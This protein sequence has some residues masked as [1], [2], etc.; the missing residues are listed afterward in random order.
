MKRGNEKAREAEVLCRGAETP[1]RGT[2]GY[3]LE[4]AHLLKGLWPRDKENPNQAHTSLNRMQLMDKPTLKHWK[5]GCFGRYLAT[6]WGQPTTL[7]KKDNS[8]TQVL[9]AF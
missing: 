2:L 4:Q 7:S 8:Y 9:N 1:L 6:S 5:N 3:M